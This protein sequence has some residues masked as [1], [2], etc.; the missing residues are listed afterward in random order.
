MSE[1][2]TDIRNDSPAGMVLQALRTGG[3][4]R[5]D[6]LGKEM[7]LPLSPIAQRMAVRHLLKT[8]LVR[9]LNCPEDY[10]SL[11][12][13]PL[14]SV[15]YLPFVPRLG[16]SEIIG[17]MEP[18]A[19]YDS[20]TMAK[21]F[22][23]S[24]AELLPGIQRAV[25]EDMVS[26]AQMPSASGKGNLV[27]MLSER[28]M[29]SCNSDSAKAPVL[30]PVRDGHQAYVAALAT[31]LETAR[32]LHP[33]DLSGLVRHFVGML[34]D[35]TSMHSTCH[36]LENRGFLRREETRGKGVSRQINATELTDAYARASVAAVPSWMRSREAVETLLSDRPYVRGMAVMAAIGSKRSDFILDAIMEHG[37]IS[38]TDIR[39]LCA[40]AGFSPDRTM[41]DVALMIRE[42]ILQCD[43]ND[44]L[45]A[46][47]K[48]EADQ[49]AEATLP[50]PRM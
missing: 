50:A 23:K 3:A 5:P 10:L 27:F 18:D 19:I 9:K 14:A 34:P 1:S 33:E 16:M 7:I 43:R 31:L 24:H 25:D 37:S 49:Q 46:G 28:G 13:D 20:H 32:M 39:R 2:K 11:T 4:C 40:A 8:G 38:R 48:S 22:R 17:A 47:P 26:V 21:S 42:G 30:D 12:V 15:R 44:M 41:S 6:D 36:N 35:R 45:E 29:H